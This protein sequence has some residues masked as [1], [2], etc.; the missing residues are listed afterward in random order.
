MGTRLNCLSEL[1]LRESKLF[2]LSKLIKISFV[3]HLNIVISTAVNT[4]V[5]HANLSC[6]EDPLTPHFYYSI[7]KLG[8]TGVYII[9]SCLL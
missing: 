5:Y 4:A 7:V 6:N 1:F 9:F 8:Y 2:V 3:F